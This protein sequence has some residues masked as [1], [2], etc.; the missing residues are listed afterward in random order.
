[1]TP[2]IVLAQGNLA[3]AAHN[4]QCG[5]PVGG[6]HRKN[7]KRSALNPSLRAARTDRVLAGLKR[8]RFCL[9][10]PP[11]AQSQKTAEA[12]I[13]IGADG[14]TA[15][16]DLAD[17]RGRHIDCLGQP[18][19]AHADPHPRPEL[20]P[21][22]IWCLHTRTVR[23]APEDLPTAL[24]LAGPAV[25]WPALASRVAG[26][27]RC[28]ACEV[29]YGPYEIPEQLQ[30]MEC[31]DG[32]PAPLSRQASGRV[33]HPAGPGHPR[34]LPG[35]V[36]SLPRGGSRIWMAIDRLRV[37]HCDDGACHRFPEVPGRDP[38][39]GP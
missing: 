4:L 24:P 35:L 1:M 7:P 36:R 34:S 18:L 16:H 15:R 31:R 26:D 19:L 5:R 8:Q 11:G 22:H 37:L 17:P 38:Q 28:R 20:T 3:V 2:R 21:H 12:Q 9:G 32:N 29:P 27:C 30:R 33:A 13:R 10:C 23:S 39:A 14:A 25:C 6:C